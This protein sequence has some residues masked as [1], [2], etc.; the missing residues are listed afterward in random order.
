MKD[1]EY[2][3]RTF[4]LLFGQESFEDAH[5]NFDMI[6]DYNTVIEDAVTYLKDGT[7]YLRFPGAA[8]AVALAAADIIANQFQEDFFE[9]LNDP[10]L[11]NGNDPYFKTYEQDKETYDMILLHISRDN[12]QWSSPRMAITRRLILQE[13]MLNEEGLK[14]LPLKSF[15]P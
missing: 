12:F 6:F 4:Y 7:S 15:R 14:I 3:R 2:R 10:F 9:V 5:K 8:R 11:M 1:Y 13:Y